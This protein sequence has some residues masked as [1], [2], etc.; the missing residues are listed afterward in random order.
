MKDHLRLRS[1]A[2]PIMPT[3]TPTAFICAV[4]SHSLTYCAL[5]T[6]TCAHMHASA[7]ENTH[8]H[9]KQMDLYE[10]DAHMNTDNVGLQCVCEREGGQTS[11]LSQC[12]MGRQ[13]M[14]TNFSSTHTH[15]HKLLFQRA[16][17]QCHCLNL[18]LNTNTYIHTEH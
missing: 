13:T 17:G 3:N 9:G 11:H 12:L 4:V 2:L 16:K 18:A 10:K 1:L 7:C 6:K 8:A 5:A 14:R 15:T